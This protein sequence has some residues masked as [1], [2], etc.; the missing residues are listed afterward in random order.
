MKIS[1]L[2]SVAAC[3]HYNLL[4][5]VFGLHDEEALRKLGHK[6]YLSLFNKQPFGNYIGL[7]MY[8]S[9]KFA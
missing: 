7:K 1:R 2:V 4:Q 9:H 8:T 5:Q 6:W 3:I